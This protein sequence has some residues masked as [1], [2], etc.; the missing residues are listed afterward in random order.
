MTVCR[1]IGL[2]RT[3]RGAFRATSK[4]SCGRA[5]SRGSSS[6]M[7]LPPSKRY[8]AT[9]N[10]RGA[11]GRGRC[12][13]S[14]ATSRPRTRSTSPLPRASRARSA[15]RLNYCRKSTWMNSEEISTLISWAR[16][17]DM[18]GGIVPVD[19]TPGRNGRRE[20]E[21]G[22]CGAKIVNPKLLYFSAYPCRKR[23]FRP[24]VPCC[25][26]APGRPQAP[27]AWVRERHRLNRLWSSRFA[28]P[29]GRM[30]RPPADAVVRSGYRRG[31]RPSRRGGCDCDHG[32]NCWRFSPVFSFCFR[33]TGASP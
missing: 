22:G 8:F 11:R 6:G 20:S 14:T 29:A 25:C 21:R 26:T 10:G 9:R 12:A 4:S 24:A 18:D 28:I 27:S 1:T 23:P 33:S 7:A 31:S 30:S 17:T 3:R 15:F 2:S 13:R 16:G 5:T 19:R 32:N